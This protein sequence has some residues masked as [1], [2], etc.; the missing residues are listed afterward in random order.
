M[1][2]NVSMISFFD[3]SFKRSTCSSVFSAVFVFVSTATGSFLQSVCLLLPVA[4]YGEILNAEVMFDESPW[5]ITYVERAFE[6]GR[7]KQSSINCLLAPSMAI[8]WLRRNSGEKYSSS[9]AVEA[10]LQQLQN[11][12]FDVCEWQHCSLTVDTEKSTSFGRAGGQLHLEHHSRNIHFLLECYFVWYV[13]SWRCFSRCFSLPN[14]IGHSSKNIQ[15]FKK[16]HRSQNWFIA[17]LVPCGRT[18]YVAGK[19]Y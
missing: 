13:I 9:L 15:F 11:I 5:A 18:G 2:R 19:N 1:C 6:I 12:W 10:Q 4:F 8:C 3:A 16:S 7:K 14:K 17:I